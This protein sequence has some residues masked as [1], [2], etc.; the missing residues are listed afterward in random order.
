MG[1]RESINKH[2]AA[3]A[4]VVAVL[5]AL[6]LYL[7]VFRS[8]GGPVGGAAQAVEQHYYTTD[9]GATAFLADSTNISPWTTPDG[10]TAYRAHVAESPDGGPPRVLYL[11]RYPPEARQQ[12]RAALEGSGNP[13]GAIT[14]EMAAEV[15]WPG[16]SYP[17]VAKS[18]PQGTAVVQN[19]VQ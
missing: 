8:G 18:S 3:A 4:A 15:K 19:S 1:V 17:W 11:E 10:K 7:A 9:D 12:L 16:G 13:G 5:V 14:A 6:I 2:P